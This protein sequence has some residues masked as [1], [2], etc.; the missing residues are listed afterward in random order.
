MNETE[1]ADEILKLVQLGETAIERGD[2]PA[3]ES[4]F[5]QAFDKAAALLPAVDAS[6]RHFVMWDFDRAFWHSLSPLMASRKW[7]QAEQLCRRAYDVYRAIGFVDDSAGGAQN[8]IAALAGYNLAFCKAQ[9]KKHAEASSLLE[10]LQPLYDRVF[11]NADAEAAK[12]Y[13]TYA[14]SKASLGLL[15]EAIPLFGK[16]LDIFNRTVGPQHGWTVTT[17]DRLE[18]LFKNKPTSDWQKASVKCLEWLDSFFAVAPQDDSTLMTALPFARLFA[19]RGDAGQAVSIAAE[20]FRC[21]CGREPTESELRLLAKTRL[22]ANASKTRASSWAT[23]SWR[24]AIGILAVTALTPL[25]DQI[26][27]AADGSAVGTVRNWVTALIFFAASAY[28]AR[29]SIYGEIEKPVRW[30]LRIA[31][32]V[33]AVGGLAMFACA[34]GRYPGLY[35][36]VLL[37]IVVLFFGALLWVC[38][39]PSSGGQGDQTGERNPLGVKLFLWFGAICTTLAFIALIAD[40]LHI[41]LAHSP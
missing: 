23:G 30:L 34:S 6:T 39:L 10:S 27:G 7:D 11:G 37:A 36:R 1:Q 13:G 24:Y 12:Y 8:R 9:L 38:A 15:A 17:A 32:I 22:L 29:L 28:L 3:A 35:S 14:E 16:A 4:F 5:M 21:A 2:T 20:G 41:L 31:A 19:A 25:T 33:C 18:N 26:G 40:V